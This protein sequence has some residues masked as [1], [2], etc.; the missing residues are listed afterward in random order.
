MSG[1]K[2]HYQHNQK[3]IP[4]IWESGRTGDNSMSKCRHNEGI[5]VVRTIETGQFI[6]R[7]CENCSMNVKWTDK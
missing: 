5:H 7:Y 6:L 2:A 4:T 1:T 3:D